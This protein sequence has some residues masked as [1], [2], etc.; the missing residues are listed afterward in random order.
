LSPTVVDVPVEQPGPFVEG[1]ALGVAV[2][3]VAVP[4]V[5]EVTDDRQFCT[6]REVRPLR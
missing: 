1:S 6:D 3:V 2:F 4:S 5:R